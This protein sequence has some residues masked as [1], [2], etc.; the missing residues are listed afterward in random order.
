MAIDRRS[1]DLGA[2]FGR[3]IC[4]VDADQLNALM[5][6]AVTNLRSANDAATRVNEL[7][8]RLATE[9]R[10]DHESDAQLDAMTELAIALSRRAIDHIEILI[11]QVLEP[12]GLSH[13]LTRYGGEITNGT[14]VKD[15]PSYDIDI[16]G[17][18]GLSEVQISEFL[19]AAF[20]AAPGFYKAVGSSGLTA[21][22][23]GKVALAKSGLDGVASLNKEE[24]TK[25]A[26]E[27]SSYWKAFLGGVKSA[28]GVVLV[29]AD[30][31]GAGVI[32]VGTCGVGAP[33]GVAEA[34]LSVAGG[35][36]LVA[37]GLLDA[38]TD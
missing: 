32:T 8:A 26:L 15:I 19:S 31:V 12:S 6:S 21:Y 1:L 25:Q 13:L 23:L 14:T 17:K 24:R 33:L 36:A 5:E 22:M 2:S 11:K 38:T 9:R 28:C 27:Q 29:G 16:L 7:V 10:L 34:T 20:D 30:L 4:S 37:D 3:A 35:M 18:A